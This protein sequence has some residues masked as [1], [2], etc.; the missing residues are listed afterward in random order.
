MWLAEGNRLHGEICPECILRGP[1]GAA[2]ALRGRIGE[3]EERRPGRREAMPSEGWAGW[4]TGRA[5]LLE[6]MECFPLTAR[7]AAV[8][9]MREKR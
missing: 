4:M 3:R 8:R 9:E 7:Q 6:A 2:K 1:R 5:R